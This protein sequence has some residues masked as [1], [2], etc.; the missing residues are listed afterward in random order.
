MLPSMGTRNRLGSLLLAASRRLPLLERERRQRHFARYGAGR[1]L[2]PV[3]A[4]ARM[5]SCSGDDCQA[6]CRRRVLPLTA[7]D[8]K[9][10][11]SL[12][13]RCRSSAK[14][15]AP[16]AKGAQRRREQHRVRRFCEVRGQERRRRSRSK[17]SPHERAIPDAAERRERQPFRSSGSR[18]LD[19][20]GLGLAQGTVTSPSALRGLRSVVERDGGA[21]SRWA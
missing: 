9:C 8:T 19:C 1:V 14:S 3:P 10:N 7:S 2:E 15:R 20:G 16:N 4:V 11:G 18:W 13:L 17:Q 21:C 6:T 5:R 12:P